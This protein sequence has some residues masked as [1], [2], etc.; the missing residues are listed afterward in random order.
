MPKQRKAEITAGAQRRLDARRLL[1]EGVAQA[2]VARRLKVSRQSVSVWARLPAS[3]LAIV[4]PVGRQSA[5]KEADR[6]WLGA[7][8]LRGA[9]AHGFAT[10]LWTL[11]R[12][13]EVLADKRGKRF[14]KVHVWRILGRL[15]FSCQKPEGRARE[16]NEPAIQTWKQDQWPALKKKP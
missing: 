4:R 5:L 16:R 10:E 1:D 11:P 7:A 13:A 2:E 12:V 3:E 15:G 14:S 6:Q 9:R 8:L